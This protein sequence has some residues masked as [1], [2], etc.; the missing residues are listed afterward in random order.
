MSLDR[1]RRPPIVTSTGAEAAIAGFV[2]NASMMSR[3]RSRTPSELPSGIED[4]DA[5]GEGEEPLVADDRDDVAG[6][7]GR[8]PPVAELHRDRRRE[9]GRRVGAG[10]EPTRDVEEARRTGRRPRRRGRPSAPASDPAPA[11]P[12][13]RASRAAVGR[14]RPDPAVGASVTTK[15]PGSFGRA[16]GVR[17]GQ[18]GDEHGPADDA[19]DHE[20]DDGQARSGP[21]TRSRRAARGARRARRPGASSGPAVGSAGWMGGAAP[22]RHPPG[23][24]ASPPS[25]PSGRRPSR[26]VRARRPSSHRWGT[27]RRPPG[28]GRAGRWRRAPRAPRGGP[29]AA[30]VPPPRRAPG[31]SRR[32]WHP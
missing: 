15:P 29:P 26:S 10:A 25:R 16:L 19:D 21:A 14:R 20:D 9:P 3:P 30:M 24:S 23:R 13:G 2:T 8:G 31:R 12:A 32:S 17:A 6:V 27:G 4:V 22:S 11:S 28:R 1:P 5:R 7:E 18:A